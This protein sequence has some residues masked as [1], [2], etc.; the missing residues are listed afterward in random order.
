MKELKVKNFISERQYELYD[1]LLNEK[2][3]TL[4]IAPMKAGKTTFVF[5]EKDSYSRKN[6][7]LF[8]YEMLKE[9]KYQLVYI[10]PAVSLMHKLKADYPISQL[11]YEGLGASLTDDYKPIIT[12]AESLYKVVAAAKD[13]NRKLY[14]VYD[15]AHMSVSNYGFRKK[16]AFPFE[17]YKDYICAGM[18]CMTA[19]PECLQIGESLFD[20]VIKIDVENKFIQSEKLNII[21]GLKD[22]VESIVSHL[23]HTKQKNPNTPIECRINDKKKQADVKEILEKFGYKVS[24]WNREEVNEETENAKL[25]EKAMKGLGIEFDILLV[26]SLIDCG[27]E[28][29]PKEKPIIIDFINENSD[30]ISDIQHLGRFRDGVKQLDLILKAFKEKEFGEKIYT[31]EETY[32]EKLN[33]AKHE[34]ETLNIFN[35]TSKCSFSSMVRCT[36][37]KDDNIYQYSLDEFA[38]KQ[39]SFKS[40]IDQVIRHPNL[41][42]L[43]L[44]NH[45]TLN[46]E[47]IDII[48]V[49][50]ESY[51]V[52]VNEIITEQKQAKKAVKDE[53]KEKLDY[54]KEEITSEKLKPKDLEVILTK[55]DELNKNDEWLLSGKVGE[56]REFYQ[57]NDNVEFRKSVYQIRDNLNIPLEEALVKMCE[58]GEEILKDLFFQHQMDLYETKKDK[59]TK[60]Y[61]ME[62]KHIYAIRESIKELNG[63]KEIGYNLGSTNQKKL[64]KKA[65]EKKYM[66]KLTGK[67]LNK[68]LDKMYSIGARNKI[69]SLKK[70][71]NYNNII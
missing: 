57:S 46:V 64:L 48:E 49:D 29:Y 70:Y 2:N 31:I 43:F 26:T 18:L 30:L 24:I 56:L 40:Y 21:T 25:Y 16:L 8:L 19:T 51:L 35:Y 37:E 60:S 58:N 52:D 47:S 11:C 65:Q 67:Q 4:L 14:F 3:C 27:V 38:V 28:V 69:N 68:Y 32:Q 55:D 61:S 42:K 5:G 6:K 54:F 53:F 22:D 13:K 39:E 44:K 20:K 41:L 17:C 62:Y 9:L 50:P 63:G 59:P 23:V 66:N 7:D 12:T 34:V 45:S 36:F 33:L 71:P 15:E 10:V 1:E